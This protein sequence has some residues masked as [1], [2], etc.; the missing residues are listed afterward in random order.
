MDNLAGKSYIPSVG[1]NG[2]QNKI[3]NTKELAFCLQNIQNNKLNMSMA[4]IIESADSGKQDQHSSVNLEPRSSLSRKQ[5]QIDEKTSKFV[6]MFYRDD[7]NQTGKHYSMEYVTILENFKSAVESADIEDLSLI[8]DSLRKSMDFFKNRK[9]NNIL[10]RDKS[11]IKIIDEI[12]IPI[13]I[14]PLVDIQVSKTEELMERLSEVRVLPKNYLDLKLAQTS[15]LINMSGTLMLKS[16]H[17]N[18]N[19]QAIDPN[20]TLGEQSAYVYGGTVI[21]ILRVDLFESGLTKPSDQSRYDLFF[22]IDPEVS[23]ILTLKNAKATISEIIV[24]LPFHRITVI[25]GESEEKP[26]ISLILMSD[27]KKS[28]LIELVTKIQR[29]VSLTRNLQD[30]VNE[31]INMISCRKDK[32]YIPAVWILSGRDNSALQEISNLADHAAYWTGGYS[33][34]ERDYKHRPICSS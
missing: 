5:A 32:K 1:A 24:K 23:D 6:E 26:I 29:P 2:V 31:A 14:L 13:E 15:S 20:L 19:R 25:S 10:E 16:I 12:S 17:L 4:Q 21:D 27:T 34:A 18:S 28:S 3:L 11:T 22:V 9:M 7:P 8:K 30:M 33:E